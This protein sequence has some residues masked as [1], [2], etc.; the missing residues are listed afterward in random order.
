MQVQII[1]SKQV[2]Y[3]TIGR[4]VYATMQC[5]KHSMSVS[6]SNRSITAVMHNASNRAFKQL[7]KTYP[8]FDQAMSNYKSAE[9]RAMIEA[10]RNLWSSAEVAA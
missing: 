4:H 6:V 2:E 10:E 7:G 3:T 5:G 1:E 9:A 8:N